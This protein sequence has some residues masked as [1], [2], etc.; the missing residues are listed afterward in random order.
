MSALTFDDLLE[1]AQNDPSVQF[2]REQ[3]EEWIQGEEFQ[4]KYHYLEDKTLPQLAEDTRASVY[5]LECIPLG[6]KKDYVE[7]LQGWRY[8]DDLRD[9]QKGKYIRWISKKTGKLSYSA[10]GLN[11]KFTNRGTNVQCRFTR[12]GPRVLE[13]TFDGQLMYQKISPEEYMVLMANQY[14]QVNGDQDNNEEEEEEEEEA[15]EEEQEEEDP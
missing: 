7:R 4:D 15:E 2:T 8:L 5:G 13:I 11:L 14:T 1:Q 3:L 9:F 6:V 12:G 10:I